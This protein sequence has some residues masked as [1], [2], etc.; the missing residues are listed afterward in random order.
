MALRVNIKMK[1]PRFKGDQPRYNAVV[2]GPRE[3]MEPRL[4]RFLELQGLSPYKEEDGV[5]IWTNPPAIGGP[6]V[7]LVPLLKLRFGVGSTREARDM[8]EAAFAE[9]LPEDGLGRPFRLSLH[10]RTSSRTVTRTIRSGSR[11]WRRP[12]GSRSRT[13]PRRLPRSSGPA[14]TGRATRSWRGTWRRS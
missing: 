1:E 3:T 12:A 8:A 7:Y 13:R 6:P 2:S 14:P 9:R 10:G 5:S 11:R 4:R